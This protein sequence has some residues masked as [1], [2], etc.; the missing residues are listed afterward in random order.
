MG[1]IKALGVGALR[2][3]HLRPARDRRGAVLQLVKGIGGH[4]FWRHVLIDDLIHEAGVRAVLKQT[5]H[6]IGQQIAVRANGGVDAA[7]GAVFFHHD[8]MQGLAHAVQ[9]LEFIG[10]GVVGHM[11]DGGNGMGVVRGELRIDAVGHV[12]QFAGV[13]DV[14]YI[15]P[16][17]A[18]EN[19]ETIDALDLRAFDLG[20]PIGPFH[21]T[22][23]DA[24]VVTFGHV[25]KRVEHH[26]R[27][28]AI[29]LH[30][31][32]K[33]VPACQRRLA[34]HRVDDFER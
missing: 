16:G 31:H 20:V 6:Q 13:G 15:G 34:H 1:Q 32:A 19:R 21:Q 2:Q 18:G 23:H 4:D 8:V 29:G 27:A 17:L 9:T 33:P 3:E 25:I 7:A 12:Q 30:H 28:R 11:Q 24:A 5:P 22:H 10:L 14:A 26:A